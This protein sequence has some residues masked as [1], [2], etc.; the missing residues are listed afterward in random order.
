LSFFLREQ[1]VLVPLPWTSASPFF[2]SIHT[3]RDLKS[4]AQYASL[5]VCFENARSAERSSR[6]GDGAK[7]AVE[8]REEFA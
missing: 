2:Q 5:I 4:S 3:T 8:N 7:L 6:D 1:S